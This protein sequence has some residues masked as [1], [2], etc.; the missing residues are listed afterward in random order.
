MRLWRPKRATHHVIDLHKLWFSGVIDLHKLWFSGVIDLHKLWFSG[1]ID[2]H[3]LW[4]SGVID[5]HK[6]WFSG[7]IDL[8]KLWFSGVIDLHKLWFSGVIDLHKL[9]FSG[10]L[11]QFSKSNLKFTMSLFFPKFS[12]NFCK[13]N[14]SAAILNMIWMDVNKIPWQ[15]YTKSSTVL[16]KSFSS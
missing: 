8:H 15:I 14:Q 7:V 9:W 10:G 11:Y 6:L 3:K 1:V 16:F 13:N 12:I 2:L 4:F 5:L